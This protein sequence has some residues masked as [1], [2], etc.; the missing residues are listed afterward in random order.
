M[1]LVDESGLLRDLIVDGIWIADIGRN[2]EHF[3]VGSA[4]LFASRWNKSL[5]IFKSKSQAGFKCFRIFQS[6]EGKS[7]GL[8]N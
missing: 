2:T 8:L 1:L 6:S 4:V 7:H 5:L 3:H